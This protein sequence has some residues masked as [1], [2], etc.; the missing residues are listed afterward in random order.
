MCQAFYN[1]GDEF[2]ALRWRPGQCGVCKYYCS[3]S[4]E[5]LDQIRPN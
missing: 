4:I 3:Q 2:E 5:D 1:N